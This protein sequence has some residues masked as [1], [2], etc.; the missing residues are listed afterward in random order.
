MEDVREVTYVVHNAASDPR[1]VIVEHPV[2]NGWTLKP[3][4]KP[5]ETSASFYRFSVAIQAGETVRLHAGERQTIAMRYQLV[6]IADMFKFLVEGPH[7]KPWHDKLMPLVMA[8][9]RVVE[10]ETQLAANQQAIDRVTSDSKRL[11]DNIQGYG[12]VPRNATLLAATP[13]K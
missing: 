2:E 4:V 12:T 7:L 11:H 1:M 10:L 5:T 3:E 8:H 9:A 13:A 6:D